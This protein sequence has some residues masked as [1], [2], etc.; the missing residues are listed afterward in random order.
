MPCSWCLGSGEPCACNDGK[1][2]KASALPQDGRSTGRIGQDANP[3]ACVAPA[4]T[5]RA[6]Y[7]GGREICLVCGLPMAWRREHEAVRTEHGVDT[8]MTL[9][10]EHSDG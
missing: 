7:V 9:C 1:A 6:H 4:S 2:R 10:W 5:G 3:R 8:D